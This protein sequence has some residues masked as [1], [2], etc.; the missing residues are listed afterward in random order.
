MR[1]AL[2]SFAAACFA[3][4]LAPAV[5]RAQSANVTMSADRTQVNVGDS[6]RLQVR[7]DVSNAQAPQ[8][9]LPDLSAFDVLSQQVSRPMQFS[10]GFGSQTQVVQSTAVYL[11]V[12]RANQPG[13][14]DL[15]APR[16]TIQGRE[17]VGNALTIVV[18]GAG[19]PQAQQQ[20]QP[21]QQQPSSAPP[22]G[23]LDGAI[24]D[25]QAFLRTVVDRSEAR[26]GEQITVTLYLYVRGALRGSPTITREATTD[27]FW[28]HDLL[29]PART[30]DAT[31]QVVGSVPFRVYVLRRFA[32]FP[33]R[34]GELT[35]GAP[36]V[37]IPMGSVFD[38]FAGGPQP[39]AERTGVP[40]TVQVR[41]LPA[42]GRPA[43]EVHVGQLGLDATLDRTQVP[44]GDAVT[45][46]LRA[47]GSGHVQALRIEGPQLDGLRVLAPQTRDEISAPGDLV[48]G[49]RTFEWL[50]VP[51]REGTYTIPPFR[52][53]TFDPA[54][55]AYRVVESAP[56]T[57]TAAGNPV[58][59]AVPS[60]Q[61]DEV[62]PQAPDAE[63]V[64]QLGPV[65]TRS[66]L[67]RGD[68]AL[69]DRAW[70]PWALA[71]FP[72]AWLGLVIGI[73]ARRRAAARGAQS[74]PQK[75]TKE[76][77]KRLAVAESH[78]EKG[79]ARAFYASLTLAL[80]SVIEGRLGESV[81][82]VTHRQLER[83]LAERGMSDAL[84]KRVVEEL[85]AYEMARFSAS[86]AERDEM[87]SALA[88]ARELIGELDRFVP[89]AE[90]E[91]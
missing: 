72:L 56:I 41:A 66:A 84:A 45:L 12:L 54:S 62:R 58:G 30:L 44:T 53:A 52:V 77:R 37:T 31:T 71:S 23:T 51:E 50:I 5:V 35:I 82:S 69:A 81:G 22:T 25:D 65:R 75:V 70:Y 90:D 42:E 4:A 48:A 26:P 61:G 29:P 9:E 24:Y 27:G 80:R 83:R 86:A 64:A 3:I 2:S 18:G 1:R 76:A 55:G 74:S 91:R 87:Q 8:P 28:V 68:T 57:L 36:T 39:D 7:V 11:F 14:F 38:I 17:Y 46:T 33:L 63:H 85:E 49:T 20:P 67:A 79:D 43:G 89:T 47:T 32:A 88:R 34:E 10:F 59:G 21:Q 15:R 19:S 73:A 16:V 40:L 6:F 78:A 60:A 13:R